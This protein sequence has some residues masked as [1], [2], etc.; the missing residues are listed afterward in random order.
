MSTVFGVKNIPNELKNAPRWVLWKAE[1]AKKPPAGPSGRKIDVTDAK[2]WLAFDEALQFLATGGCKFAGLGFVLGDGYGGIDLDECIDEAGNLKQWAKAL[3]RLLPRTYT[4]I[5]P[6][7]RGVKVFF[8]TSAQIN[9]RKGN[10][11]LYTAGRYFTITGNKFSDAP[12]FLA[13]ISE[14]E[15][16][17]LVNKLHVLEIA[18]QIE[19]GKFGDD[20]QA[21]F[22]GDWQ[23]YP[24][25]SEAEL[26]FLNMAHNRCNLQTEEELDFLYRLSG[27]YRPKWQEIHSGDGKTYGELTL[28]KVLDEGR[29]PSPEP[30][31]ELPQDCLIGIAGDFAR[32]FASYYEAP[33][34]FWFF[35]F[36]TVLGHLIAGRVTLASDLE[37]EPRLY[38]ILLGRSGI[39]KKSTAIRRTI[40]FFEEAGI[41]PQVLYGVGSAEGLAEA[42]KEHN[43]LLLVA[44]EF[45]ALASK[46]RIEGSVLAP[47]LASLFETGAY[48]NRTKSKSVK[49]RD[50]ALSLLAASTTDSY[51]ILWDS[52]NIAIG[53]PNRLLIVP[54]E[55]RTSRPFVEE[56]P[57][58]AQAKLKERL[59]DVIKAVDESTGVVKVGNHN[60]KLPFAVRLRFSNDAKAIWEGWYHRRPADVHAT[61]L[62]TIGL[63]L[64]ILL[65]VSQGNLEEIDAKTISAVIKILQWQYTA[66]LL[67]DP[68][69]A[70]NSVAELEE[71]IRRICKTHG[72]VKWRD[73]CK[74]VHA[75]R[76]GMWMFETAVKNLARAGEIRLYKR[77]RSKVVEYIENAPKTV[78]NAKNG[79]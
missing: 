5:S 58:E 27:L 32:L 17:N 71:K 2:N 28:A 39:E 52:H 54:A 63:R 36:L 11:E 78:P 16:D 41:A 49:I 76:Y 24:S 70:V 62:D 59:I 47:M 40:R 26:A 46:T 61:R 79:L 14:T 77:G 68:V 9:R 21:L 15:L 44:D 12:Q 51:A 38:T 18:T 72:C 22:L 74:R 30:Q 7:G 75:E 67:H 6:S 10:V 34:E 50:A 57:A 31:T 64:A 60:A 35:S 4:E 66:R 23:G 8:K 37:P 48:D 65:A 13:E 42:L 25:Q 3:L 56:I 53:L 43:N 1:G 33:V 20:I 73:L 69:D 29:I 55:A 45:R 19:S